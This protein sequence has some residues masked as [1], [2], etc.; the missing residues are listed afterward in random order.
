[1][2]LFDNS[3]ADK[4]LSG[5]IPPS[6]DDVSSLASSAPGSKNLV[7]SNQSLASSLLEKP[8]GTSANKDLD[9]S[10]QTMITTTGDQLAP[11]QDADTPL[12]AR[13]STSGGSNKLN[14]R[15]LNLPNPTNDRLIGLT[16]PMFSP[17][18]RKLPQIHLLPG[19]G[20]PGSSNLWSS[21]LNVTNGPESMGGGSYGH[22]GYGHL[23]SRKS[24][25]IP[26]ESNMRTGLTP[27]ILNQAGFN[28]NLA[29]P[30]GMPSGQMTPGF[31]TLLGLANNASLVDNGILESHPQFPVNSAP[32]GQHQIHPG[33]SMSAH[34]AEQPFGVSQSSANVHKTI[35]DV[36]VQPEQNSKSSNLVKPEPDEN[37]ESKEDAST[38]R[39]IRNV[40]GVDEKDSNVKKAKNGATSKAKATKQTKP[41]DKSKESPV[42]ETEE[43]K[44][45]K[46]LERNRVAATKCRQRKKRLL[47]KMESELEFYSS[48]FREL[49]LQVSQLREQ[50]LSLHGIIACHKDCPTLLRAVGGP[51]QMQAI[52]AQ[53]EY[54]V[55]IVPNT[56]PSVTS[57]PST[58]PTTLN[59]VEPR[60]HSLNSH[61]PPGGMPMMSSSQSP[62]QS[63][64]GLAQNGHTGP[65]VS[66][67]QNGPGLQHGI[68]NDLQN[69]VSNG[70]SNGVPGGVP[71]GH[72]HNVPGGHNVSNGLIGQHG[73]RLSLGVQSGD[74][75]HSTQMNGMSNSGIN[76]SA[77]NNSGM[78]T[79]SSANLYDMTLGKQYSDA[80][81]NQAN[82]KAS[83][84]TSDLQNM[85][86][87]QGPGPDNGLRLVVSM[88]DI[89]G[90]LPVKA[91]NV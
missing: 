5:P 32:L 6:V 44:R 30:G 88:A 31:Q 3:F 28:F 18:G 10:N 59:L 35:P 71:N 81:S 64:N 34:T 53:S 9:R 45:K 40:G 61:M 37:S 57:M 43:E 79:M 69:G 80:Y 89:P 85:K 39:L 49:S 21:L 8:S 42:E 27:G 12:T 66:N 87:N 90:Q 55:L 26:T 17:G 13:S 7:L 25:L 54:V 68:S 38:K 76:G 41:D 77:M 72:V 33:L 36:Q 75:S 50:V 91:T 51:Q 1:M 78:G 11:S 48:G 4:N 46:A 24:G 82:L 29:T 56:E 23:M 62:V 73:D 70:I 2:N 84:S 67:H 58:I 74:L 47:N 60:H 65:I 14:L 20:S 52:L 63:I 83:N 16:P 22:P 86:L 15:I 19:L